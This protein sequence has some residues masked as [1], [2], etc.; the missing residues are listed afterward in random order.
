MLPTPRRPA[1]S[2]EIN[3]RAVEEVPKAK[4]QHG[5]DNRRRNAFV[6][7]MLDHGAVRWSAGL[8][9]TRFAQVEEHDPLGGL[10]EP[11]GVAAAIEVRARVA[12]GTC[13]RKL[14]CGSL[15]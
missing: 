2:R 11:E 7:G 12:V 4:Q 8:K 9:L 13:L 15:G 14:A 1:A 6:R 5:A 10:A 3:G